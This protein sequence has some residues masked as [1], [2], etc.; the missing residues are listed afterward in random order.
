MGVFSWITQDTKRSIRVDGRMIVY[1]VDNK[2]N[3]WQEKCYEGYGE[4]G[5]KDFHE[6]VA[7]MNGLKSD[8]TLGIDLVFSGQDYLS[9]NLVEDADWVWVNGIPDSCPD[10]GFF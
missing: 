4:F 8:R 5:G 2:G 6:L 1:L 7:E 3:K 10:Q 9:P